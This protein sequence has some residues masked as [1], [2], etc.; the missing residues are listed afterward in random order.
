MDCW[1]WVI[2]LIKL[3]RML[4]NELQFP[5][6]EFNFQPSKRSIWQ[7]PNLKNFPSKKC[8]KKAKKIQI[9]SSSIFSSSSSLSL[10]L[11]TSTTKKGDWKI[12]K[13]HLYCVLN[14]WS[15]LPSNDRRF[16]PFSYF[17]HEYKSKSC[18]FLL[19]SDIYCIDLN[20]FH[21]A[22]IFFM[23]VNILLLI[24]FYFFLMNEF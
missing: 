3:N 12:S 20:Q 17:F 21:C 14:D 10:S 9:K 2:F 19:L 22:L 18:R 23:S 6:I 24:Y 5:I 8:S 4:Q 1:L 7:V 16:L 11:S 13:Q 15:L